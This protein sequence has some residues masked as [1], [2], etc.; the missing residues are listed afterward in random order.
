M[1]RIEYRAG[2]ISQEQLLALQTFIDKD[3]EFAQ[4]KNKILSHIWKGAAF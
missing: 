1:A 4:N 3:G 2:E